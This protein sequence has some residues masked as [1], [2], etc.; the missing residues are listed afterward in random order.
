MAEGFVQ[1]APDSTGKK[2]DNDTVT[3]PAGSVDTGSDGST[4]VLASPDYRF[5]QR[6]V[7]ADPNDPRAVADVSNAQGPLPNDYGLSVRLPQG[8]ADL[9]TIAALLLDIDTNIAALA[10]SVPF[11]LGGSIVPQYAMPTVGSLPPGQISPTIPRPVISDVFGR[12]IVLPHTLLELTA[13]QATTITSSTSETTIIT[14]SGDPAVFNDLAMI[15]V[16]N[17]S[18]S[19]VRVD[20][21][22]QNSTVTVPSTINGVI[23]IY[24]PAGEMR[25][26]SPPVLVRQSNP[27][28]AWTA[29]CSASVADARI[30]ALY[31]KNKRQ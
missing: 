8:Q 22:D 6:I 17:T 30:W 21:R 28:Q 7:I 5:R 2:I 3:F 12:Q 13:S 11:G 24:I 29:T 16:T 31:A 23:P 27:N 10:G 19:A 18:A 25:G 20:I 14:A 26:F 9:Q 1:V 4:T 15:L